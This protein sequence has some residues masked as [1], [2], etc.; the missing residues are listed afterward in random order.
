[1]I[2]DI[3]MDENDRL[4]KRYLKKKYY[5][6][7]LKIITLHVDDEKELYNSL[8]GMRDTLSDDVTDY[9]ER[10]AETILPLNKINIKIEC[11]KKVDLENF[12]RC[13][14]VHYGIENLNCERIEKMVN[15]KKIFLLAVAVI[16]AISFAFKDSLYEIKSFALTLSIWE[17]VD[18]KLYKDEEEDIKKYIFELLENATVVE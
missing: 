16:T 8:D 9:L 2:G 4:L 17:Y 10:S 12:Q 6:D 11:K 15:N 1:M 13:L 18:M 3:T 7:D 14:K 5:K